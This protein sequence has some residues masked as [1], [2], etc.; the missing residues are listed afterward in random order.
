MAFRALLVCV[1]EGDGVVERDRV[2]GLAEVSEEE[3]LAQLLMK[4]KSARLKDMCGEPG[5]RQS[6]VPAYCAC[7]VSG[8]RAW[9]AD[10]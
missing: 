5:G 8:A 10:V 4:R 9:A 1:D 3:P 7:C 2:L 6:S